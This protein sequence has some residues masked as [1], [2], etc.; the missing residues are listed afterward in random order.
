M[1]PSSYSNSARIGKID[2][3]AEALGDFIQ[4]HGSE[5]CDNKILAIRVPKGKLDMVDKNEIDLI[6]QRRNVTIEIGEF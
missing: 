1:N 2:D 5:R 3:Y 4:Y 6:G